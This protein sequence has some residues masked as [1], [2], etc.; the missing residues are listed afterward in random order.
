[1]MLSAIDSDCLVVA[2]AYVSHAALET[3]T[4]RHLVLVRNE[5]VDAVKTDLCCPSAKLVKLKLL[6]C[7]TDDGLANF[8][9]GRLAFVV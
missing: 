4:G 7:P 3:V 5:Y 6:K 8:P 1:M 9:V 2:E